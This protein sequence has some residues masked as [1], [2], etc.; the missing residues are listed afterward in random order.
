MGPGGT[1][2][3]EAEKR[4]LRGA[5]SFGGKESTSFERIRSRVG[6][7]ASLGAGVCRRT[8]RVKSFPAG[9]ELFLDPDEIFRPAV[10]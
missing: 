10:V 6:F 1:A 5:F 8:Q 2:E 7:R 9:L 3:V 4:G